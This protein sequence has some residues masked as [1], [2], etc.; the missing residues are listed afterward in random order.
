VAARPFAVNR[1]ARSAFP[2]PH[3]SARPRLL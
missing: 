1:S 2:S 3:R